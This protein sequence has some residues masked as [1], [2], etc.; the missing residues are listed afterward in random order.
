MY[1]PVLYEN[2]ILV[3]TY[4]VLKIYFSL[5]LTALTD[6]LHI[7]LIMLDTWIGVHLKHLFIELLVKVQCIS[8]LVKWK[9]KNSRWIYN[10]HLIYDM[11]SNVGEMD[12]PDSLGPHCRV[13]LRLNDLGL[14]VY[15]YAHTPNVL[16]CNLL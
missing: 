15:T 13:I 16:S 7:S 2:E 8:R 6:L 4:I 10:G 9:K 11:R 14:E 12:C 5:Y 3:G 1:P